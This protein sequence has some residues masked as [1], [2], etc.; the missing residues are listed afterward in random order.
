M[1]TEHG[2]DHCRESLRNCLAET[3]RRTVARASSS[4][5]VQHL[6]ARASSWRNGYVLCAKAGCASCQCN[7][8]NGVTECPC[9]SEVLPEMNEKQ[10]N[11][12]QRSSL[13][14]QVYQ[15]ALTR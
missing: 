4:D 15:H 7:E 8:V 6:Q 12:T 9:C 14:S 10:G 1:A 11:L 5:S 13:P 3:E 2:R